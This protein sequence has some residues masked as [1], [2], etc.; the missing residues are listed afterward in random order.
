M[1]VLHRSKDKQFYF[2][3]V[4]SNGRVL[5]TSETYTRKR[6]ALDG[7][8]AL[9]FKIAEAIKKGDAA[10]KDETKK[11]KPRTRLNMILPAKKKK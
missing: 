6:N 9:Q 4:A 2:T 3:V 8:T 10:I 7:I 1:I 11:P 5:V